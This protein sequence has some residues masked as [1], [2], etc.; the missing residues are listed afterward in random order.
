MDY[1]FCRR[2]E[3]DQLTTLLAMKRR[4]SRAV[5]CWV[6]PAKGALGVV[7][8]EI[9]E[10]GLR[11]FGT[12]GEAILKSDN[13]EAIDA[14]RARVSGLRPGSVLEQTPAAYAHESNGVVENGNKLG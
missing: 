13:E 3:E 4:Q 9:A 6:V 10:R 12:A 1:A 11:D 14:L 2:R 7:A 5:R 8:A